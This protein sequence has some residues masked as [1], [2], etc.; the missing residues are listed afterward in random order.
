MRVLL[1]G[2]HPD[3]IDLAVELASAGVLELAAYAGPPN[4][5][6]HWQGRGWPVQVLRDAEAA[7]ALRNIDWIVVGDELPFRPFLLKRALQSERHVLVV[8]PVDLEPDVCYE[9]L[10][11]L[12]D[13]KKL[14]APL[15]PERATV[16]FA[17]LGD[18][19]RTA[20]LG[21]V[22]RVDLE[23]DFPL[24]TSWETHPLL[25]VWHLPRLAAGEIQELTA[26][27]QTEELALAT[28]VAISGRC[29][30]GAF[31][32]L[33]LTP[34]PGPCDSLRL[35]VKGQQGELDLVLPSGWFGSGTLQW[36]TSAG[37]QRRELPPTARPAALMT[38]G[39][40]AVAGSP[41]ATWTDATR[42]LEL[43][44]ATR[45]SM[46]RRRLVVMEYESLGE[47][48]NFKSTMATLGCGLMLLVMV[49]FFTVP[50][51]PW[52]KWLILPLLILFLAL[53]GLRWLA[54]DEA[55]PPRQ[56]P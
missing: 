13:T 17:A 10:L 20:G 33:H 49:L 18:A 28:A 48:G 26:L 24:P 4:V 39:Q 35:A 29:Q 44:S 36:R 55:K 43:F 50:T 56:S 45:Q 9:A 21:P 42:C 5:A 15:L 1:L 32:Q 16:A 19:L 25:Q 27:S 23:Y 22:Q 52:L 54:R 40:A 34:R 8:H 53:Q 37:E 41:L 38:L 51:V 31:F 11:I 3:A 47:V 2:S 46:R 12:G 6:A 14:L 7:L 30:T